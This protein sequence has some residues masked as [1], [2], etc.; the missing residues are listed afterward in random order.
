MALPTLLTVIHSLQIKATV[1]SIGENKKNMPQL[2]VDT[3]NKEQVNKKEPFSGWKWL[4]SMLR[5]YNRQL[6]HYGVIS[7]DL[8]G[9]PDKS[10]DS[11]RREMKLLGDSCKKKAATQG[12][13][14]SQ[15][16]MCSP[17]CTQSEKCITTEQHV[18]KARKLKCISTD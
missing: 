13:R 6:A 7:E 5:S 16:Q 11:G 4:S 1:Y 8:I 15:K 2:S 12:S 17:L 18:Y 3:S 10:R 9:F 14:A